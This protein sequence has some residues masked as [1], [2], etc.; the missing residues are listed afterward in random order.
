MQQIL[1]LK[2]LGIELD[3]IPLILQ[4]YNQCSFLEVIS[5]QIYC[6]SIKAQQLSQVL[7]VL[8]N[9]KEGGKSDKQANIVLCMQ[10]IQKFNMKTFNLIASSNKCDLPID[11]I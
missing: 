3:N 7:D 1:V 9:I 10:I 4:D 2:L 11:H 5:H 8:Q 6:L